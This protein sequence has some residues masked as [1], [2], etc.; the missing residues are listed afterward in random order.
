M[1]PRR[2][3]ST[4]KEGK[5]R[6]GWAELRWSGGTYLVLDD[7]GIVMNEHLLHC[8]GWNLHIREKGGGREAMV[9]RDSRYNISCTALI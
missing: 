5:G 7:G 3:A 6:D 9:S 2:W 1:S 4:C 8:H